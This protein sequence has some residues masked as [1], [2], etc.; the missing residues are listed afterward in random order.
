VKVGEWCALIQGGIE[1]MG[2][3]LDA[4]TAEIQD[5]AGS[6]GSQWTELSHSY[7][8]LATGVEAEP[9]TERIASRI[10]HELRFALRGYVNSLGPRS[11]IEDV[12]QETFY[13][14]L[15]QLRQKQKV[16]N[17]R[18]W[19]F[20]VAYNICMDLHRTQSR[21]RIAELNE[22]SFRHEC[23][24]CR[25]NPEW[26]YLH[27]EKVRRIRVAM[28][29]LPPR[30]LRSVQLRIK[31][32]RYRDIAAHL[33]VSEQRATHLVKRALIRLNEMS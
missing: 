32:L 9:E 20:Q 3:S 14:L 4:M 17:I 21:N 7:G 27:K 12:V 15:R 31:G 5:L 33:Q 6:R 16:E 1:D 11:E 8:L 28:S 26:M 19:I 18:A 22:V 29:H 10:Y 24:D 25:S 13:R 2:E 23:A 30:Q